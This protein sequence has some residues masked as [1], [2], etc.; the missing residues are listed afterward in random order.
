MMEE[1]SQEEREKKAE[2]LMRKALSCFIEGAKATGEE[3]HL[4]YDEEGISKYVEGETFL[5]SKE[6]GWIYK[7][8]KE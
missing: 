6:T 3:I 1:M 2:E 5:V 8:K 4:L 7:P